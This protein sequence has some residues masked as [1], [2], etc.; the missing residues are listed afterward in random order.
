MQ[1][2]CQ[3]PTSAD[4]AES[5]TYGSTLKAMRMFVIR[6]GMFI[7]LSLV[8]LV[9]NILKTIT[10][11]SIIISTKLSSILTSECLNGVIRN[12]IFLT[13][14]CEKFLEPAQNTN[15]EEQSWSQKEIYNEFSDL[16]ESTTLKSTLKNG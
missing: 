3:N 10:L 14:I 5:M 12:L 2:S 13:A 7:L 8:W 9:M 1:P 16:L 6:A 4:H 11:S 15:Q